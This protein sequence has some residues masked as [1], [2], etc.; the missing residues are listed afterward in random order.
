M[1]EFRHPTST[2]GCVDGEKEIEGEDVLLFEEDIDAAD[3]VMS[4]GQN[5]RIKPSDCVGPIRS[6]RAVVAVPW[7]RCY[8]F[9][10]AVESLG[11]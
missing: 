1:S 10:R 5:T 8:R 2:P 4:N 3:F 7:R 9:L 11:R 6:F